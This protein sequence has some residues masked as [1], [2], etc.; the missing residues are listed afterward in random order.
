MRSRR[1]LELEPQGHHGAAE[2]VLVLRPLLLARLELDLPLQQL[3]PLLHLLVRLHPLVH[4]A[5]PRV[6]DV[7]RV[8]A[9]AFPHEVEVVLPQQ[10]SE[11]TAF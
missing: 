4:L 10:G 7:V 9:L 8:L 11:R 5:Q 3:A 1:S 2:R 6:V